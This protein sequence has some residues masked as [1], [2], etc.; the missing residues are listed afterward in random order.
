M[1]ILQEALAQGM[2]TLDEE[3][4]REQAA[5]AAR[6]RHDLAPLTVDLPDSLGWRTPEA[7]AAMR[8]GVRV[9]AG[10]LALLAAAFVTM[11]AM[12]PMLFYWPI[13]P[14]AF[15]ALGLIGRARW[16]RYGPPG[17][18][19]GPGPWQRPGDTSW[20]HRSGQR[21]WGPGYRGPGPW[22]GGR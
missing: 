8:R 10:V 18:G 22:G 21:P 4:D 5:Y 6:Y 17:R 3:A 16:A 14:L 9:H 13:F 2:L 11:V 12:S 15:L 7:T 19:W 20:E 1:R